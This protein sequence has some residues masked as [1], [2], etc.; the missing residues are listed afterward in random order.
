MIRPIKE[1]NFHIN[2]W[3]SA[4]NT[5]IHRLT[6]TFFNGGNELLWDNASPDLIKKFKALPALLGFNT[7]LHVPVL[8]AATRLL[9][10][11]SF[12]LGGF[13]DGFLICDLRPSDVRLNRKF[14]LHTV[15]NDLKVQFTHA[16]NN[17]I[18]RFNVA[19]NTKGWVF[20]G[21]TFKR[22]THFFL[23][24]L[25]FRLNFKRHYGLREYD[26]L[27]NDWFV[28]ITQSISRSR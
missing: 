15:N 17:G 6:D 19:L 18:A 1:S 21:K 11:F 5:P 16:G 2:H 22:N 24:G 27:K 7:K 25:C 20:I 12:C 8:S 3:V 23:I 14:P 13:F 26:P 10:V 4:K 28:G 9:D